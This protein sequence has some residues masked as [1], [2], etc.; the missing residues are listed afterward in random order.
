MNSKIG[1]CPGGRFKGG[2]WNN[3]TVYVRGDDVSIEL[4]GKHLVTTKAHYPNRYIVTCVERPWKSIQ[5]KPIFNLFVIKYHLSFPL[6]FN[7]IC[8]VCRVQGYLL[9]KNFQSVVV[10]SCFCAKSNTE[11]V[12]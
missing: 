11:T 5:P 4:D 3:V 2:E 6:V 9:L 10:Y 8:K 1:A 12:E 7:A